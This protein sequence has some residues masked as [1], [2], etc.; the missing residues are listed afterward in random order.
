MTGAPA[1]RYR[2]AD[3]GRIAA[4]FAADIAVFDPA[5]VRDRATFEDGPR[6]AE[7]F[8]YVLV[9]GGLAVDGGRVAD[10]ASG[11]ALRME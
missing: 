10:D 3:R 5:G 7:G 8:D 9:N 4:G 2:M 6:A 11:R 1:A